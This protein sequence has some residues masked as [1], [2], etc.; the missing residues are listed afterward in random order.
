MAALAD[1]VRGF[2]GQVSAADTPDVFGRG[3]RYAVGGAGDLKVTAGGAGD[4]AI[5]V[6]A[7]KAWGDGVLAKHSASTVLNAGANGGST[8]RWDTLVERRVWTSSGGTATLTLLQGG[9]AQAL[10]SGV[11][12]RN[13]TG[14]TG[15]GFTTA[16]QPLYLV[17]VAPGAATIVTANLIDLR[18]WSG[19]GGGLWGAHVK[20][21]DYVTSPGTVVRI[22]DELH[23]RVVDGTGTPQWDVKDLGAIGGARFDSSGA[24]TAGLVP[25]ARVEVDETDWI[26]ASLTIPNYSGL[27]WSRKRKNGCGWVKLVGKR[28]TGQISG[29]DS[30]FLTV[31]ASMKPSERVYGEA[32]V[33]STSFRAYIEGDGVLHVEPF[34]IE[35]GQNFQ[36]Y[37]PCYPIG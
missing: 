20:A 10:A 27:T 21:R 30:S 2:K 18:L 22:G 1:V 3:C 11:V 23:T 37:I 28:Q 6:A 17:P 25:L 34:T 5:T 15:A 12:L 31:P 16:D 13:P 19:E 32:W 33:G 8:V 35:A 9:S 24:M 4:R 14:S 26:S 29:V 7:G 36:V